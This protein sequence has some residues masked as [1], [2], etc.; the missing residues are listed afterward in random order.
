MQLELQMTTSMPSSTWPS[1]EPASAVPE[2]CES[3]EAAGISEWF[4]W[5]EECVEDPQIRTCHPPRRSGLSPRNRIPLPRYQ[6]G[7]VIFSSYTG[8]HQKRSVLVGQFLR[9]HLPAQ[10]LHRNLGVTLHSLLS[11]SLCPSRSRSLSLSLSLPRSL[12]LSRFSRSQ[13]I[14]LAVG[15]C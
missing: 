8:H 1:C 10:S 4:S 13:W 15:H 12:S 5:C 6:L 7:P 2:D 14:Q 9:Y 11:L 3:S